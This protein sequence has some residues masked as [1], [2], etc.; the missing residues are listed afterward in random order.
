MPGGCLGEVLSREERGSGDAEGVGDGSEEFGFGGGDVAVGG[1]GEGGGFEDLLLE[2]GGA[3]GEGG[4]GG[5]EV[6][7]VGGGGEGGVYGERIGA[8][9]ECGV[10]EIVV[11]LRV[12][13]WVGLLSGGGDP[14]AGDG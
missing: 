9:F 10:D 12:G 4:Q 13:L 5:V 8:E 3:L 14:G 11:G 7:E 6:G 2:L 1:G